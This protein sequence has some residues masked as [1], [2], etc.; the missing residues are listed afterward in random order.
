MTI[1]CIYAIVAKMQV[2]EMYEICMLPEYYV[3]QMQSYVT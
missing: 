1:M 3:V 2:N